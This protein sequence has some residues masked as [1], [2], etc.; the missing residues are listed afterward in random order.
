MLCSICLN[1]IPHNK[2]YY[3]ACNCN[4]CYH[5]DCIYKW[6]H[7]NNICP[8]CRISLYRD[9]IDERCD[10]LIKYMCANL[11]V[12]GLYSFVVFLFVIYLNIDGNL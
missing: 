4:Y 2:E 11:L 8:I 9:S 1:E 7:V 3:L 10:K 6:R 12:I 5:V